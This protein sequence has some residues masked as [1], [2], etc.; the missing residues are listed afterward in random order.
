[1]TDVDKA[2]ADPGPRHQCKHCGGVFFDPQPDGSAYSHVCPRDIV[3]LQPGPPPSGRK[4]LPVFITSP[5]GPPGPMLAE[6]A[7]APARAGSGGG[8][9]RAAGRRLLSLLTRSV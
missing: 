3:G 5:P 2:P 7:V 8:I 6:P 4:G 1:M 9:M